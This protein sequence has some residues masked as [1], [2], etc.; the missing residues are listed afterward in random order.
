ML[1]C[2]LKES[3]YSEHATFCYLY[4]DYGCFNQALARD[5]Y[6]CMIT[7]FYDTSSYDEFPEI[8]QE[9]TSYG[10]RVVV[11]DASQILPISTNKISGGQEGGPRV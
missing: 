4:R 3:P 5:G 6:R 2:I 7:G 11:T 10:C 1:G 9:A 8:K